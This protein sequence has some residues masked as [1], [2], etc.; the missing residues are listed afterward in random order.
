[1]IVLND[2][3]YLQVMFLLHMSSLHTHLMSCLSECC[4][5]IDSWQISATLQAADESNVI[6][7]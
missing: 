3:P 4:S 7:R 6:N 5:Q 1:M 2:R